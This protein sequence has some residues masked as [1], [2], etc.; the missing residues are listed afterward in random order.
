MIAI[1]SFQL[2]NQIS[3]L[4]ILS[5]DIHGLWVKFGCEYY[6]NLQGWQALAALFQ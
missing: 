4:K 1:H 5:S 2:T 3:L 6:Y